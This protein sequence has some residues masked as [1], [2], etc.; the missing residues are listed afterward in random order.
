MSIEN[1]L[2]GDTREHDTAQ[3]L[4]RNQTVSRSSSE[5]NH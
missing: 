5:A 4:V 2:L 3:S 1:L